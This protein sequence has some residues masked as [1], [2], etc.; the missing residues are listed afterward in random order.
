MN[1]PKCAASELKTVTTPIANRSVAG[2]GDERTSLEIDTCPNCAGV[3]FNAEELDRFLDAK[4]KLNAPAPSHQA[5]A[6][7]DAKSAPCPRCAVILVRKPARYNPK[8]TVDV[9]E[10]CAGTWVDGAELDQAGGAGLPFADR[11]KAM[12]GDLK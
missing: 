10:K 11:M 1:C 3:W 6:E 7:L 2:P 12:F 4:V 9:C 5:P 8:I